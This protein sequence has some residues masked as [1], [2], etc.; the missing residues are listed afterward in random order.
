MTGITCKDGEPSAHGGNTSSQTDRGHARNHLRLG[1]HGWLLADHDVLLAHDR[2]SGHEG[3]LLGHDG[4]LDEVGLLGD[5]IASLSVLLGDSWLLDITVSI[6]L[7]K[8]WKM[9][10]IVCRGVAS[11]EMKGSIRESLD[12]ERSQ[13]ELRGI[14][15]ERKI[16]SSTC[17]IGVAIEVDSLWQYHGGAGRGRDKLNWRR[18]TDL[19]TRDKTPVK[20]RYV[21]VRDRTKGRVWNRW[22]E[23]NTA[24]E[25]RG[26]LIIR[27]HVHKRWWLML[28]KTNVRSLWVKR[29]S[30]V[31]RGERRSERVRSLVSQV[32]VLLWCRDE[33]AARCIRLVEAAAG[34]IHTLRWVRRSVPLQMTATWC[35]ANLR[36]AIRARFLNGDV[37]DGGAVLVRLRPAADLAVGLKVHLTCC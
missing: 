6:S 37:D 24:R 21:D 27:S 7:G 33:W 10:K 5:N 23:V 8:K 34:H 3:L 11:G 30:S 12:L 19:N 31:G 17:I 1:R 36:K 20:A 32:S 25:R 29:V 16:Y 15:G 18:M 22:L 4:L 28:W 35:R 26:I 13:E 2:L 14:A 9:S